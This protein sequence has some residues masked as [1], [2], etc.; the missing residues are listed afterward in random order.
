MQLGRESVRVG[1]RI[2]L[3]MRDH[4]E[5]APIIHVPELANFHAADR[6][7]EHVTVG[8]DG[9]SIQHG[10][11]LVHALVVHVYRLNEAHDA[12]G[13]ARLPEDTGNLW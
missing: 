5:L 7:G 13:R 1:R 10:R 2:Q 12:M 6:A 8:D 4:R 3:S 11:G 9:L